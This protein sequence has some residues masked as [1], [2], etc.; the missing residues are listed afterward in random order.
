VNASEPRRW[1]DQSGE[2]SDLLRRAQQDYAHGLD[3]QRALSR[4][5]ERKRAPSSLR[6]LVPVVALGVLLV[7]P[8]LRSW[9]AG[10]ATAPLQVTAEQ[11]GPVARPEKDEPAPAPPQVTSATSRREPVRPRSAL[12]EAASAEQATPAAQPDG[13]PAAPPTPPT[14]QGPAEAPAEPEQD[15]LAHARAGD[16]RGAA[17][18]FEQRAQGSGL[19]AQVALYELSRLQRDSLGQPDRALATLDQ[20][21]ARFPEGSLGGE[22]RFSRLELLAKLG[23]A[24]EAFAAS[25]EFLRSRFGNERA[26]EVHLLR[27]NLLLRSL[28]QPQAAIEEYRAAHGAPGRIGDEAAFQMAAALEGAGDRTAARAAYEQ[29]LKRSGARHAVAARAR[30]EALSP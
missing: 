12:A 28:R 1:L 21:L 8:W 5:D 27:G 13:Q 22:A 6:W 24:S 23:R 14:T 20:Y 4:F 2:L 19:S 18:C 17:A 30:L 3:A 16:P 7:L 9:R 15:C 26:A 11:L 10:S 25:T 29:Y